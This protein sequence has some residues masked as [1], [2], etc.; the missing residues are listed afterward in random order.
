MGMSFMRPSAAEEAML[1]ANAAEP[2]EPT[3]GILDNLIAWSG[4]DDWF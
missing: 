4:D 3:P 2:A 1:T